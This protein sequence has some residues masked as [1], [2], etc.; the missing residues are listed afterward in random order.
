MLHKNWHRK[1]RN[2]HPTTTVIL[3]QIERGPWASN[4]SPFPIKLGQQNENTFVMSSK[5]KTPWI[6]YNVDVADSQFCIEYLNNNLCSVERKKYL[7][8]MS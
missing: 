4:M 3:H 8:V 6:T 1:R 7:M 5:G 2:S